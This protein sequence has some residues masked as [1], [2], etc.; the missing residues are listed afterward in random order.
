V[1][2]PTRGLALVVAAALLAVI[3]SNYGPFLVSPGPY[4][5]SV[6]V[7]NATFNFGFGLLWVLVVAVTFQREPG[8]RMWKLIL[9]FLVLNGSW[10]LGFLES[11]LAWT[12]SELLG[13]AASFVLV[14]LVLAFPTGQLR[15]RADRA[16]IGVI[17]TIVGPMQVLAFLFYDPGWVDCGPADW[18]PRNLLMVARNDDIVAVLRT[19]G[20]LAP[21]LGIAAA[22]EVIRHWRNASPAARRTLAPVAFGMPLVFLILGA[23]WVAP[24]LDRDDIR[25]FM[26]QNKVF[27]VPSYLTP[28][29]FLL[30]VARARLARGGVAD[31]IVELGRGV[32]LGGLQPLLARVLR[33]PTLELAY[34]APDGV[35]FVDAA[36][37][38]YALPAADSGRVVKTLDGDEEPLGVLVHDPALQR[39]DPELLDAVAS[40]ARLAIENER[41]AAQVRA[42]LDEVRA[43]HARIEAAADAERRK[44]ERD[45]HDGA[46]Q[47]LVALADR[48]E[49]AR[50]EALATDALIDDAATQLRAAVAEVRSLS[51]GGA[52][53]ADREAPVP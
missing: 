18:C 11:E 21:I 24:A 49:R 33:D 20:L 15:D 7:A 30:G 23:W 45:L 38:P 52:P 1:R 2:T 46:Q 13:P 47:R 32:P 16:L 43:S 40:V 6:T 26:L 25:V 29:L 31:L 17:L 27:D 35:G 41:L 5:W 8:G 44:V 4:H 42:Q 9:A 50:G 51:R 19:P 39:E 22:G 10:V 53:I 12:L 37:R 34:A 48:L 36:G 28:S 3:W 14:L